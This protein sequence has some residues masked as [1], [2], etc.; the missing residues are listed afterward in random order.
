MLAGYLAAGMKFFLARVD[1]A[2]QSELGT[3][4]AA[5]ADRVRVR[6]FTLPIRLGMLNATGPQELLVNLLTRAG[7]VEAAN[8]GTSRSRARSRSRFVEGE[9]GA[10][11]ARCSTRGGRE[12]M[13]AVFLEYAW[14]MTRRDPCAADPSSFEELRELGAFWVLE[15]AEGPDLM[16]QPRGTRHARGLL[17]RLHLRDDGASFQDDLR[18]RETADQPLPGALRAAPSVARRAALRGGAR[19]SGRPARNGSSRRRR[20]WRA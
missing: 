5:A 2:E 1:L 4:P 11:T 12:N 15:Q 9:F 7:R 10:S 13:R 14:D 6:D 19:A 20:T 3:R 17:T 18:F 16:P 8:Y